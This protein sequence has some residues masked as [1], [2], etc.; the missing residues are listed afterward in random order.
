MSLSALLFFVLSFARAEVVVLDPDHKL[1]DMAAY[2]GVKEWSEAFQC[3]DRRTFLRNQISCEN[4]CSTLSCV[5]QCQPA[6]PADRQFDLAFEECGPDSVAIY[7]T[8]GFSATLTK[9]D[10]LAHGTWAAALLQ[11]LGHFLQPV[12]EIEITFGMPRAFTIIEN[13]QSRREFGYLIDIEQQTVPG[14]NR[15]LYQVGFLTGRSALDSLV[16]FATM[17]GDVF[18]KKKG[19]SLGF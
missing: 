12:G 9:S 8:N 19:V 11:N 4:K 13:G 15:L 1:A 16:W 5:S 3:G 18:L 2:I 10:Y 6:G 7:G 17:D 14:A